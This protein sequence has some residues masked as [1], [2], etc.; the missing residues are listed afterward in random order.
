MT[1]YIVNMKFSVFFLLACGAVVKRPEALTGLH[2]VS[3]K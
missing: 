3:Q 1:D 2:V